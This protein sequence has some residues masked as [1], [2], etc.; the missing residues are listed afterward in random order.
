MYTL[1]SLFATRRESKQLRRRYT[2]LGKIEYNKYIITLAMIREQAVLDK[3]ISHA[4]LVSQETSVKTEVVPMADIPLNKEWREQLALDDLQV[5][6]HEL[7]H[8]FVAYKLGMGV[9]SASIIPNAE[10]KYRGLTIYDVPKSLGDKEIQIISAAGSLHSSIGTGSDRKRHHELSGESTFDDSLAQAREI[11]GDLT[12]DEW[13]IM[14]QL[15]VFKKEI[16]GEDIPQMLR[17]ARYELE[18]GMT[19]DEEMFKALLAKTHESIATHGVAL[20]LRDE[21]VEEPVGDG[22]KKRYIRRNGV[23]EADSVEIVCA[24]CGRKQG[25]PHAPYCLSNLEKQ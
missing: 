24:S 5:A 18:R 15:F 22:F 8:A 4:P 10:K 1:L 12:Q 16:T 14:V 11:V 20:V 23:M 7:G 19:P 2:H 13:R 25:T 9:R 17:R 6:E 3:G 21:L